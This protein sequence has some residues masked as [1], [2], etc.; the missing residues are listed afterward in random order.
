MRKQARD[1]IN[2]QV[3]TYVDNM[4]ELACMA[5]D[6]RVKFNAN[7]YL[8]DQCIGTATTAAKEDINT[9]GDDGKNDNKTALEQ[10]LENISKMK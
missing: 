7:K 4:K 3:C 1:K 2:S 5:K 8:I 6:Q 10:R 9:P